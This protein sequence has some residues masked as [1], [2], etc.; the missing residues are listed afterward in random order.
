MATDIDCWSPHPL[1]S[2]VDMYG[3]TVVK[4]LGEGSY[5]AV[6]LVE[7]DN[8][9]YAL[10]IC[11]I[12]SVIAIETCILAQARHPNVAR[13]YDIFYNEDRTEIYYL[14]EYANQGTVLDWIRTNPTTE[15]KISF[16]HDIVQGLLFLHSKGFIH[17]DITLYNLLVHN[18]RGIVSDFSLTTPFVH[19]T[20]ANNLAHRSPEGYLDDVGFPS[21]VWGLGTIIY[22]LFH[23]K[24]IYLP[25]AM[26]GDTDVITN[27]DDLVRYV[28]NG[29][30]RTFGMPDHWLPY[31]DVDKY[32]D[33]VLD[34]V[35]GPPRYLSLELVPECNL[36]TEIQALFN[37]CMTVHHKKRITIA[38]IA[39]LPLFESYDKPTGV[40]L[41]DTTIPS[42]PSLGIIEELF[43]ELELD[44]THMALVGMC[45][46][47]YERACTVTRC[48]DKT[49]V[50][51]AAIELA[52][53][54][55]N[56][57][58]LAGHEKADRIIEEMVYLSYTLKFRLF[59]TNFE[60]IRRHEKHA[61]KVLEYYHK[62]LLTSMCLSMFHNHKYDELSHVPFNELCIQP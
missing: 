51:L 12:D 52:C 11:P 42:T 30:M 47:I 26:V 25:Y 61:V 31:V 19:T 21:D 48:L 9:K 38:N 37:S 33:L 60:Y 53:S 22:M 4:T 13:C 28:F 16:I 39:K 3:Y 15:M 5:G 10:K 29:L 58:I 45:I 18:N 59:P 7:R 43:A 14:M 57:T 6:Y 50:A 27:A 1:L 24:Y 55:F 23:P 32:Q 20:T 56:T 44:F 41:E 49:I 40:W 46:D 54:L 36:H 2:G 35:Y 62:N 34:K 8:K 17:C